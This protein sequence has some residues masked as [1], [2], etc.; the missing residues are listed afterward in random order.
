MSA[1]LSYLKLVAVFAVLVG[2]V[3][4]CAPVDVPGARNVSVPSPAMATQRKD[5]VNEK[6]DS[7]I[8]LPLGSGPI[9]LVDRIML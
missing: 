5:A 6:P 9:K 1:R 8:Y 3:S 2:C 4:S 7:V